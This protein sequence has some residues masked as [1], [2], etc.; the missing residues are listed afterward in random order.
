[1]NSER[2]VPISV[3]AEFKLVRN[4]TTDRDLIVSVLRESSGVTVDETGTRVKPNISTP[5][6]TII[7]RDIAD[8][9]ESVRCGWDPDF[10]GGRKGVALRAG[11][12]W[13]SELMEIS[14]I[15]SGEEGRP[16]KSVRREHGNAWFVT[17]ETEEDALQMLFYIRGK[18]FKGRPIAGRMKSENILKS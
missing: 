10:A 5:R 8:A 11:R 9:E 3:I 18:N 15:F 13:N 16:V 2:Y 1:M 17:F 12:E 6:N 4:L 14:D 7:L